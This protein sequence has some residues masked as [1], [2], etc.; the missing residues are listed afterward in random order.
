MRG[1]E[2]KRKTNIC[3]CSRWEMQDPT[4]LEDE[5]N[6]LVEELQRTYFHPSP[7]SPGPSPAPA[8]P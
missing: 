5:E 1:D 7:E 8:Q 6:V 2:L 3:V 4:A